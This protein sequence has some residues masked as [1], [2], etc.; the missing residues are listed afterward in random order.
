LLIAAAIA[1][2]FADVAL[3][4]GMMN[5][6]GPDHAGLAVVIGWIAKCGAL[7]AAFL[8]WRRFS[9]RPGAAPPPADPS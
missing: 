6:F 7:V 2:P 3:R 8:L 4:L 1:F 9:Q 5:A